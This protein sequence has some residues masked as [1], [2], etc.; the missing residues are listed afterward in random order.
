MQQ[1][2]LRISKTE[3]YTEQTYE[4]LR[5]QKYFKLH[6][7]RVTD[8]KMIKLKKCSFIIQSSKQKRKARGHKN[9]LDHCY[10]FGKTQSVH[11]N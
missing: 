6:S 2:N 9:E 1:E 5:T 7:S 11:P 8:D 10:P 3:L 4:N